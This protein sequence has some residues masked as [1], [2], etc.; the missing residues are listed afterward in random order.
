MNRKI[1]VKDEQK[2]IKTIEQ[3]SEFVSRK[4]EKSI[5]DFRR[6][7]GKNQNGFRSVS[8]CPVARMHLDC[9]KKRKAMKNLHTFVINGFQPASKRMDMMTTAAAAVMAAESE[10]ATSTS[11]EA[12]TSRNEV[13]AILFLHR[14][15]L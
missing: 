13:N 3:S 14:E 12:K 2:R 6:K 10:A 8:F 4:R 5:L 9:I 7:N 1:P 15:M 11:S